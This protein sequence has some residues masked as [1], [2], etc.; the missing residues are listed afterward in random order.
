M[1]RSYK[2]KPAMWR[3][4][5]KDRINGLFVLADEIYKESPKL[6]NRYVEIAR[7]IGMKFKVRI[8]KELKRRYCK[9]CNTYLV[10]GSNCRVRNTNSKIVYSCFSCKKFMRFPLNSS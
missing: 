6:S 2:K 3:E 4:I 8:S 9:H 5:A 7:N 10:P 1:K